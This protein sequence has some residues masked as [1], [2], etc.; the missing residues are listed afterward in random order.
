MVEAKEMAISSKLRRSDRWTSHT[1][2]VGG[3][4]GHVCDDDEDEDDDMM[5]IDDDMAMMI[6]DDMVKGAL[7]YDKAVRGKM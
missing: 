4:D 1:P 7:L 3:Q 2:C 6:D 5:M